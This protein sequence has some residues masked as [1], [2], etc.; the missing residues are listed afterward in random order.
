MDNNTYLLVFL[1]SNGVLER[2]AIRVNNDR[3]PNLTEYFSE[4]NEEEVQEDLQCFFGSPW[5]V[6]RIERIDH[7]AIHPILCKNNNQAW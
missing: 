5:N 3:F 2:H 6:V 4:W 1:I 7:I